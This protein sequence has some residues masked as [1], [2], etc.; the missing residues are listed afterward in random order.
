MGL[1]SEG[2]RRERDQGGATHRLV[3]LKE[4]D[5]TTLVAGREIVSCGVEL[6]SGYDVG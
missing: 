2:I 1:K 3:P 5:T 6:D 4:D